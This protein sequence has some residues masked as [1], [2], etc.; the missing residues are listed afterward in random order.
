MK[1]VR[2]EEKKLQKV[3]SIIGINDHDEIF[4][5]IGLQSKRQEA[6]SG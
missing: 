6:L 5:P 3:M 2:E 1:Q 4:D